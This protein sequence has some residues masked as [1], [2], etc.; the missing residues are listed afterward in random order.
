M[1]NAGKRTV[2]KSFAKPDKTMTMPSVKMDIL[3]F[4]DMSVVLGTWEPGFHWSKHVSP[5]V[6]TASCQGTHFTYIVSGRLMT[7]MDDG[8]EVECGPGDVIITAPGHDVWVVG[9]EPC[10]GFDFQ[11]ASRIG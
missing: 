8:T 3:Q 11:P 9:D 7:R 2:V 4:D 5:T 1:S 10:V 6:G